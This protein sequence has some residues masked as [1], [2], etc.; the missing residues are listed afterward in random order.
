MP[1]RATIASVVAL[2]RW[3]D[4]RPAPRATR[5]N[6]NRFAGENHSAIDARD[7]GLGDIA[8]EWCVSDLAVAIKRAG[9]VTAGRREWAVTH[10]CCVRGRRPESRDSSFGSVTPEYVAKTGPQRGGGWSWGA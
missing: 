3:S 5:D 9:V 10:V 6:V 8:F 1:A 7:D 2:L 4:Q